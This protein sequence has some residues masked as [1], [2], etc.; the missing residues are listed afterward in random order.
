[1]L[2]LI[3]F[4]NAFVKTKDEMVISM[5]I[6]LVLTFGLTLIFYLAESSV[7][8]DVFENYGDALVWGYTRYIEGGDGI[9]DGC[10]VTAVGKI[11]AS[12]LGF[13]GIALV[14]IPAGLIGSGFIDAME[15]E[16]REK[17]LLEYRAR[18]HKLFRRQQRKETLFRQ[19]P[20]YKSVIDFQAK[21]GMDT[22]DII[23]TTEAFPEFRL[24]NLANAEE[25]A[26]HPVDRLAVQL[27]PMTLSTAPYGCKID[28][29]SRITIVCPTASNEIG[30]GC[31][32]YYLALYGGFNYISR[33][34]KADRDDNYSYYQIDPDRD[35]PYI[36]QFVKDI[37]TMSAGEGSWVIY[38]IAALGHQELVHFVDGPKKGDSDI[39]H[40]LVTIRDKDKPVY[41]ALYDGMAEMLESLGDEPILTTRQ[42]YYGA[43]SKKHISRHVGIE[44]RNQFTIRVDYKLALWSEK[45]SKAA[46]EMA[47]QIRRHLLNES[48]IEGDEAKRWSAVGYGFDEQDS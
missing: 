28:R 20:E 35:D 27:V 26:D 32:S 37:Q 9:F 38:V 21:M 24:C 8:P 3:L 34:V 41:L 16:K 47:N 19:V 17:M 43:M 10:P 46:L 45:R 18:M 23:E 39:N 25:H 14:A 42:K 44:G 2:K 33:E 13:M 22:K 5:T 4:K 7:Q 11:I 48:P 31:F 29:A 1:M 36:K 12:F 15:E 30:L 6:L 40:P